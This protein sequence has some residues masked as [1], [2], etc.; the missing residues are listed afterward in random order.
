MINIIYNICTTVLS[1]FQ[2][3][4]VSPGDDS[5]GLEWWGYLLVGVACAVVLGALVAAVVYMYR[6]TKGRELE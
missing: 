3:E 5:G 6:S 1:M 4:V 2:I